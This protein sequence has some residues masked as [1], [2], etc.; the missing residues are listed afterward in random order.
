VNCRDTVLVRSSSWVRQSLRRW[1]SA[2]SASHSRKI[3]ASVSLRT[4]WARDN[5]WGRGTGWRH[6]LL[7]TRPESPPKHHLHLLRSRRGVGARCASCVTPSVGSGRKSPS[8]DLLRH[9]DVAWRWRRC[10]RTPSWGMGSRW[11]C[12]GSS[13]GRTADTTLSRFPL[14]RARHVGGPGIWR[15]RRGLGSSGGRSPG[16]QMMG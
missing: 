12:P 2:S 11:C 10:R 14:L 9:C 8:W 13:W 6:F 3:A 7:G 4:W 5:M 16:K 15:R 1:C